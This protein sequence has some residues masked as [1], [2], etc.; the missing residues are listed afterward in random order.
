ML[1]G[2]KAV[3][4]CPIHYTAGR[5]AFLEKLAIEYDLRRVDSLNL[6]SHQAR[7]LGH[8][9]SKEYYDVLMEEM[10]NE[11]LTYGE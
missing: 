3:G 10:K 7:V 8:P 9:E 11:F 5:L 2:F 4:Q 1:L 6:T